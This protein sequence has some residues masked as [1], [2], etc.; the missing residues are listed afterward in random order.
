MRIQRQDRG[1][2]HPLGQR[3][4]TAYEN[5]QTIKRNFAPDTLANIA[6]GNGV[7]VACQG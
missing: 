5:D 2:L 6:T 7:C 4:N 1:L 3:T